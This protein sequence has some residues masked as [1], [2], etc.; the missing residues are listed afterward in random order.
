MVTLC[1][2]KTCP[3]SKSHWNTWD[4]TYSSKIRQTKLCA[5]ITTCFTQTDEDRGARFT[6]GKAG[7]CRG[8]GFNSSN[9]TGRNREGLSPVSHVLSHGCNNT[10]TN[11]LPSFLYQEGEW[12]DNDVRHW[13]NVNPQKPLCAL[14]TERTRCTTHATALGVNDAGRLISRAPGWDWNNSLEVKHIKSW[15]W[16][17]LVNVPPTC[18]SLHDPAQRT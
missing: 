15:Y 7:A 2:T 8:E 14:C 12:Q 6:E 11:V 4:K 1:D 3:G 17:R 18:T 9:G 13:Q 5:L 10:V 16:T